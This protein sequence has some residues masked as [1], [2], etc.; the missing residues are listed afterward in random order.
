MGNRVVQLTNDTARREKLALLGRR[1]CSVLVS[2]ACSTQ[3]TSQAR[4]AR[5]L[6]FG[7]GGQHT[8]AAASFMCTAFRM[9]AWASAARTG[10][11][12]ILHVSL[13]ADGR[14]TSCVR[15]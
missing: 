12:I 4:R 11:S 3:R 14:R 1:A 15:V 8:G 10:S 2:L 13:M 6:T 9:E 5:L 7:T